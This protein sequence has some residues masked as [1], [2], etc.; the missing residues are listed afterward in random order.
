M[1]ITRALSST[2]EE[3]S[4]MQDLP[5]GAGTSPYRERGRAKPRSNEE[6]RE[7]ALMTCPKPLEHFLLK[8]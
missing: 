6:A 8:R 1:T 3:T 7:E 2:H 4:R 5:L